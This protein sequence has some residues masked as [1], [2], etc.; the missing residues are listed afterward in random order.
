MLGSRDPVETP[1][2]M[3]DATPIY[4]F[5]NRVG[6]EVKAKKGSGKMFLCRLGH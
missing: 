1:K 4:R 5:N 2:S 6:G 3:V